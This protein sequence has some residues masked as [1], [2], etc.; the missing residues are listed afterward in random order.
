MV[1]DNTAVGNVECHV[2]G[3]G[4]ELDAGLSRR[5]DPIHGTG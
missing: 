1:T 2:F 3:Y 4:V 5:G